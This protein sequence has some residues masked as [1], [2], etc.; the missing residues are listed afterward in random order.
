M[1]KDGTGTDHSRRKTVRL[2][3]ACLLLAGFAA[4][5][6]L[7]AEP[8]SVPGEMAPPL[9][10]RPGN[11]AARLVIYRAPDLGRYVIMQLSIDGAP[12]VA[13]GYGR[14]FEGFLSPGRHVLLLLPTPDP[15]WPA[16]SQMTLDMRSGQ[17]YSFTAVGNSGY[18]ILRAPGEPE[19]P[20]GR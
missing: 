18:L 11:N 20:R 10:V 15:K 12:P 14:T 8:R 7:A 4:A 13:L 2:L 19:L 17:T 3:A 1:T 16:P 5:Q 6:P 9:L